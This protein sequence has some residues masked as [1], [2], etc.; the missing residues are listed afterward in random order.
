VWLAV[1]SQPDHRGA[2]VA[3]PGKLDRALGEFWVNNP[4]DIIRHGHNLSAYER[5]RVYLNVRGR[6]FLDIS[7]LSGAD[8]DG[9]GRSVVAGDFGNTGRLDLVVRQA[10]GGPLLLYEND[11]PQ[12][13]YLKVTLRGTRSNRQGIGARLTAAV[14]GQPLVRELY[15]MNS[16]RSQMPNL[17]HFGLGEATRVDR[18]TIRWP[19]G[20]VQEFTDLAADRHIVVDEGREGSAAVQT[21]LPGK[22]IAP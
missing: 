21:V 9:D 6:D 1:V 19:S 3:Q 13:H 8:N 18:L 7:Y 5:K 15:P 20:I 4:W 14:A 16:F 2:Q 11:F 22:T 17:V 12:R 10:G